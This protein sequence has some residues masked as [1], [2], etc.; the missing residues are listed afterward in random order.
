MDCFVAL[1]LRKDC[2]I[3]PRVYVSN[4]AA[5]VSIAITDA[6]R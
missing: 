2:A 3:E 1:L 6:S 5:T 4:H